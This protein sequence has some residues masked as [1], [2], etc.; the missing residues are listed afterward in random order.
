MK[1]VIITGGSRGIGRACVELYAQKGDF[2]A[3]IYRSND[4]AAKELTSKYRNVYAVKA[5]LGISTE[6]TVAM[7]S[8][9]NQLGGCDILINNA[10]IA[11]SKLM[12]DITDCDFCEMLNTNLGSCFYC[13]RAV[14]SEFLKTHSGCIINIA[15]MWGEVGA[16][17]EVHYSGA[18]AGVIGFTKALAKELGP[19]GIRVNCV[20]PGMIDTDMNSCYDAQTINAIAEETPLMRIGTPMDVANAVYFLASDKA[21]FIT[22]QVLGVNGGLVI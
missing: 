16:S 15:S 17:M 2:V 14:I 10:G 5:D 12:S 22:G 20:S 6:A 21:S 18:K 11:Q 8:A 4:K 19:S 3:F 1:R 9:I 7:Q 13:S